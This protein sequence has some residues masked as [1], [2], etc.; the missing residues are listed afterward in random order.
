MVLKLLDIYRQQNKNE[1]IHQ[2]LDFSH[3]HKKISSKLIINLNVRC[4]S[5]KLLENNVGKNLG[6]LGL[7][8]NF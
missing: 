2:T 5:I 8:I 3:T 6:D 1:S 7:V 4:K